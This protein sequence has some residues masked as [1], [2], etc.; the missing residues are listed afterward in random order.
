VFDFIIL[1]KQLF[2]EVEDDPSGIQLSE[3]CWS[4][5]FMV[6]SLGLEPKFETT[7]DD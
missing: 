7:R 5:P 6:L 3:A 1:T 2:L 4:E